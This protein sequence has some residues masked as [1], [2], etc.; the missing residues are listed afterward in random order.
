MVNHLHND[1]SVVVWCIFNEGWGQ[2]DT[3]RLLRWVHHMDP[4]R[5]VDG[6]SGW[7]DHGYGAMK[8]AHIYPGPGMWPAMRRRASVLGESGRF[9]CPIAGHIW[10][11]PGMP[12]QSGV[13]GRH[14]AAGRAIR[15]AWFNRYKKW[16]A[17]LRPL[18]AEGL[19]AGKGVACSPG[20]GFLWWAPATSG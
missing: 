20:G 12:Y 13:P 6:P 10:P 15:L 16:A 19:A 11:F 18:I 7:T 3:N 1:P 2:H 17:A 5:L 4:T 14:T 9:P 8:D